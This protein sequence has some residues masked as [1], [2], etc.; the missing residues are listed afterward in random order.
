MKRVLV[1]TSVLIEFLRVRNRKTVYE[2]I[3]HKKYLPVISFITSAE[4]WA[5][6][7]VWQSKKK[8]EILKNL[9]LGIE[10]ILPSLPTL[11]L[12]G[13]L[14]VTYNISLADAFIAACALENKLPLLT[15]NLKDFEKVRGIKFLNP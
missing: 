2:E 8:K 11:K 14:K 5:G 13:K 12:S 6:S 15:L 10:I 3:L 7:S 4:L 1:D 9:L